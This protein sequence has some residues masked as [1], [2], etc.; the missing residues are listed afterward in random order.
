[1]SISSALLQFPLLSFC[2]RVI[3]VIADLLAMGNLGVV[4][5]NRG[6]WIGIE[7]ER[8]RERERVVPHVVH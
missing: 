3:I 1:M 6:D 8:E 2:E 4:D 5:C 7:R